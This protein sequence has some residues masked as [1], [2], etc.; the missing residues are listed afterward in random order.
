[1]VCARSRQDL[2]S[3]GAR[4]ASLSPPCTW[5]RRAIRCTS[6]TTTPSRDEEARCR[7]PADAVQSAQVA[8]E[9]CRRDRDRRVV[10]YP[11]ARLTWRSTGAGRAIKTQTVVFSAYAL[12]E[13]DSIIRGWPKAER[14]AASLDS[15]RRRSRRGWRRFDPRATGPE[16]SST[17][18]NPRLF[19]RRERGRPSD[20]AHRPPGNLRRISWNDHPELS[21]TA[22]LY[23]RAASAGARNEP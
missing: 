18:L 5:S 4:G 2:L 13:R 23:P 1:V 22:G 19:R 21:R 16:I 14:G 7:G 15:R 3:R 20:C 9:R 12:R 10:R 11:A 6:S 8:G 17:G